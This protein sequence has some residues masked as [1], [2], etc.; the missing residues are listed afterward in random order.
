[1][2]IAALIEK[3]DL[4]VPRYTSYPTAA[5]F[6]PAVT[7]ADYAAW[8]AA[9]PE[10][11]PVSLY[12]H[13]PF[14]EQ[15]CLYCGC[16]TAVVRR[17]DLRRAYGEILC[18]EIRMVAAHARRRLTVTE[19]HWGGGT[20]TALPAESLAAI[21]QTLR[22]TF[23][24]AEPAQLSVE[25]DPRHVPDDALA[26]LH[27]MGLNRASLGVQDFDATVQDAVGRVQPFEMVQS[28]VQRLRALGVT[29]INLDL[30]Y[31]LPYQTEA[32]VRR[33]A[34]LAASLDPERLCAFG[35]AH[36]P[37][38]KRH[39]QLLPEHALPDPPT[40]FAQRQAIEQ[41][42]VAAG[43]VA[44]GLDHFAKPTDSM[45]EACRDNTLHRN[46][47]G[48]TTDAAPV[49][50]GV[51]A[52]AIGTT[53]SGY[54][55]NATATA[56]YLAAIRAGRF[57]TA[58]GVA[59]TKDDRLRRQVIEQILCSGTVDL[60]GVAS[61]FGVD[62]HPLLDDAEALLPLAQDGLV[63]VEGSAVQVTEAGRP[64]IR[65]VA[66]AFDAYWDQAATRHA[67]AI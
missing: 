15:L 62:P 22:E 44:I 32:S 53:P 33:S 46:F 36:V 67:R 38:M 43:Y 39:Q 40:R 52:S 18:Q 24:M 65:C 14:C 64:F 30:M 61:Q 17:E 45:A 7:G 29:S 55:Q 20:P 13:V 48:Y 58:R 23:T 4:R 27:A 66:A 3:Y 34:A 51:G 8:L 12:L 25:F 11:A 56:D 59:L 41:T 6:T 26:A 54:V 28:L 42:L 37:W 60:A 47:Q 5:Q 35:Y 21:G 9:L 50:I 63:R 16:N 31:G 49:L 57:A 10:T 1:M 2:T 19:I